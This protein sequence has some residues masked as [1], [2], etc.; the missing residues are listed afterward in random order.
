MVRAA[1]V[2]R[3]MDRTTL[4][5][6]TSVLLRR[7]APEAGEDGLTGFAGLG[8][9]PAL[10]VQPDGGHEDDAD[11]D[12]LPERLDADDD[13]P[14]CRVVGMKRPITVPNTVPN[15]PKRLV[16]PMTTPAMTLRLVFDCP[17]MVVDWKNDRFS[18][19]A[20]PASSPANA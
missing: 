2:A 5:L 11:D 13:E 17:P 7:T 8:V 4:F 9:R 18:R 1:A 10:L 6:R 19:P 15:P 16:P 14:L 20:K 3:A 12:L